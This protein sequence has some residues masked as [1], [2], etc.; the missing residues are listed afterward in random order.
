MH[1]F[2]VGDRVVHKTKL[3]NGVV[4]GLSK[5]FIYCEAPDGTEYICGYDELMLAEPK[6]PGEP[7]PTPASAGYLVM[8]ENLTL[9]HRFSPTE[10]DAREWAIKHTHE[11][12][13]LRI[14]Y[15]CMH[16]KPIQDSEVIYV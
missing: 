11:L 14:V 5:L 12:G 15:E 16:V 2:K 4:R 7:E 1:K 3:L 6:E 9:V 10:D 8:N 13:V